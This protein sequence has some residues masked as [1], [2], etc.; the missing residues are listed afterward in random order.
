MIVYRPTFQQLK[1]VISVSENTLPGTVDVVEA[2]DQD[3]GIFGQVLYRLEEVD[4]N[5]DSPPL[6]SIETKD[7]KGV[8][9]LVG[10]LDYEKESLHPLR[11][12]AYD[13]APA[14]KQKS[15]TALLLIRVL[16]VPDE[17]P[18]FT[19]VPQVTKLSE[20]FPIGKEILHVSAVD[21]DRE[22]NNPIEYELSKGPSNLFALNPT[23]GVLTLARPLEREELL[24][25]SDHTNSNTSLGTFTL[26]IIA[27]ELSNKSTP[28]YFSADGSLVAST[29]LTI[30]V[31]DET[32]LP[33][34]SEW[35]LEL[36]GSNL[37]LL[38]CLVL[39]ICVLAH[40]RSSYKRSRKAASVMAPFA[41][42]GVTPHLPNTNRHSAEGS[43]PIWIH[44]YDTQWF[45]NDSEQR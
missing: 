37:I 25:G 32:D 22:I 19:H 39:V 8:I 13:R 11:I 15:T 24:A 12:I 23:T 36:L 18:V 2:T 38:V 5:P 26:E 35:K 30:I 20:T 10:K 21:G 3:E 17:P 43:N 27:V 14:E 31:T 7:G 45:Q 4:R 34:K 29:E 16:D 40:A 42:S 33:T 9:S 28:S 6:F 1:S 44:A 41:T